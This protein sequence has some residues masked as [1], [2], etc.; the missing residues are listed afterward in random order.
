MIPGIVG[1]LGNEESFSR[2]GFCRMFIP[3][4]TDS[5]VRSRPWANRILIGLNILIFW[6][7]S[8]NMDEFAW[9]QLTPGNIRLWQFFTY[10]FLHAGLAHLAGNMLF[11]YIFGNNIN[12]RLG[13]W[14]YIAFY[15]A[16]GIFAG[17]I[18]CLTSDS[19]VIGASGAVSA[20]SGAYLILLP[21][22]YITV[23]Y[24]FF[25]IGTFQIASIYFI[26]FY[27]FQDLL[28]NFLDTGTPVAHMAHVGGTVFGI[29]ISLILLGIGLLP[30]TPTDLLAMFDLWNRRRQYRQAV[31]SGW[32]P[33]AQ[34]P[35][36]PPQRISIRQVPTESAAPPPIPPES[37]AQYWRTRVCD[38]LSQGNLS[39]AVDLYTKEFKPLQPDGTLP[40]QAQLD[41]ANHL[42]AQERYAQAAEAYETYLTNYAKPGQAADRQQIQQVWLM[43]GI[44]YGRYLQQYAKARHYLELFATEVHNS[45]RL[46]MAQAEL[47]RLPDE[48]PSNNS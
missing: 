37:P 39:L 14:G 15:L 9:A 38:V 16:G 46:S 20:I 22:S 31:A 29:C 48:Q 33:Y 10:T 24:L 21:R 32:N 30:R 23:L 13:H 7:T 44:I 40:R 4:R 43:I 45:Q 47:A 11:L 25:F 8:R 19:P 26:L 28:L 17:I 42:A 27:F 35:V 1:Q 5:P 36:A 3:I 18:H 34:Q 41:V 6:I 2:L 12:D